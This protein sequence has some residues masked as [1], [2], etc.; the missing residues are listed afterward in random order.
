MGVCCCDCL[1]VLEGGRRWAKD[2]ANRG[3]TGR[4]EPQPDPWEEG[5]PTEDG[6]FGFRVE[7]VVVS[8]PEEEALLSGT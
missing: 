4:V 8:L 3:S 5:S 6:C 2:V 7:D 1:G